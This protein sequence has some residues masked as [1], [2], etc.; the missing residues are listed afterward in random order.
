MLLVFKHTHK[1]LYNDLVPYERVKMLF[2]CHCVCHFSTE[3]IVITY[4]ISLIR[5]MKKISMND[6]KVFLYTE[7]C[8]RI[9]SI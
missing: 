5:V 2:V 8:S 3:I 7:S 9:I 6:K 4:Y 1:F